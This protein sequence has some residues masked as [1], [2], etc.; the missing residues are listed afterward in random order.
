MRNVK[1]G[2]HS[3]S[4]EGAGIRQVKQ[5][6]WGVSGEKQSGQNL[7]KKQFLRRHLRNSNYK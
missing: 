1:C 3:Y 2:Y 6:E 5:R 4:E 7:E